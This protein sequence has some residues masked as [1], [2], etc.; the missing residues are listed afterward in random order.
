[1][2]RRDR[3]RDLRDL[4]VFGPMSGPQAAMAV[5]VIV[6][7]L[8]WRLGT[9]PIVGLGHQEEVGVRLGGGIPSIFD[10]GLY[11]IWMYTSN[12]CKC[13]KKWLEYR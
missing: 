10:T 8:R 3:R 9:C 13:P 2:G 6:A 4:A 7:A 5:T 11:R 12:I 1:M